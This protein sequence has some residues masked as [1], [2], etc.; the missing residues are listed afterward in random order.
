MAIAKVS[1]SPGRLP[2]V[3]VRPAGDAGD[4]L[5][6]ALEDRAGAE[7]AAVVRNEKPGFDLFDIREYHIQQ[8]KAEQQSPQGIGP[9]IDTL[10]RIKAS[11]DGG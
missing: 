6:Q 10:R 8:Q 9:S 1:T 5:A 7:R 3:T 4:A 11:Q 2:K